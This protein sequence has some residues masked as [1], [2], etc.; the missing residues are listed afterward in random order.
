MNIC[1]E[2]IKNYFKNQSGFSFVEVIL[3]VIIVGMIVLL[4]VNLPNSLGLV[5]FS[6]RETLAKDIISTVIE[7][8]RSR[9][10]SNL[11]DPTS[12]PCTE[13]VTDPRLNSLNYGDLQALIEACPGTICSG[14]EA[15]KKVTVS[16]TWVE[17]GVVEKAE[18]STLI[19][20]GGLI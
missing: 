3:V 7:D 15:V 17:K 2:K 4:L 6:K 20:N 1:P 16:V 5:G 9:G 14:S 19:S 11:C 13:V 12:S 18:V 8:L 10:Y